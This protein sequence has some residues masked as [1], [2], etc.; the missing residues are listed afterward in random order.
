LREVSALIIKNEIEKICLENSF[1][2]SS[3]IQKKIMQGKIV[4]ESPQGLAVFSHIDENLMIAKT[5]Q[6]PICQDTG[7]VI[8]FADIGQ[9]VHIVDGD[10]N[11]AI[12]EGVRSAYK[13]G[14]LRKSVVKDPINRI[15]TGDNTPAIIYYNIVPGDKIRFNILLKG[16]GSENMS[17]VKMLKPSDGIEGIVDFVIDTVKKAGPN[18]CPPLFLGLGIGGTMEKAAMLAKEALS[19]NNTECSESYIQTLKES[20]INKINKMGI[21]PMGLGGKV[22]VLDLNIKTFPTHI[23]GLPV[24]LN[25]GCHVNRHGE[26]II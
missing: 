18:A 16:F 23:A 8:V 25:V 3:E 5:K 14:Y 17:A 6:V 11:E 9:D 21:G 12:N 19:E 22:T 26:V 20:L 13:N 7:M 4:E 10:I 24:A 1:S 2:L 15:N